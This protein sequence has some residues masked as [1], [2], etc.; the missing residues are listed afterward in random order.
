MNTEPI[1]IIKGHFY[2]L[3]VDGIRVRVRVID[4]I[5]NRF[6]KVQQTNGGKVMT[7]ATH[8]L[9]AV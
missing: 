9:K 7:C 6:A 4:I 5:A 1:E 8:Q 3:K 2:T